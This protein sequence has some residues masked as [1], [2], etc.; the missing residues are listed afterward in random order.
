MHQRPS[1]K[2]LK[3]ELKKN[4]L[5]NSTFVMPS[6]TLLVN[7]TSTTKQNNYLQPEKKTPVMTKDLIDPQKEGEIRE[8]MLSLGDP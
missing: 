1:A 3:T 4:E 2:S 8:G 5:A 6:A 7:L